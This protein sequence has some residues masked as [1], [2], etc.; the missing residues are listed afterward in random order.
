MIKDQ[1]RNYNS[2]HMK[3]N[4]EINTGRDE[5]KRLEERKSALNQQAEDN[6]QKK[7]EET[8]YESKIIMTI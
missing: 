6:N 8:A 5:L 7:I 1:E 4:N 3:L 2:E